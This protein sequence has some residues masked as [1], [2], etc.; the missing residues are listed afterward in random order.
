MS[1]VFPYNIADSS[2]KGDGFSHQ[3]SPHI[4][5]LLLVEPART[6]WRHLLGGVQTKRASGHRPPNAY[7]TG[8][9][10]QRQ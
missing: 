7:F 8:L 5:W 3:T 6:A 9:K 4:A 10:Q 2:L 1:D